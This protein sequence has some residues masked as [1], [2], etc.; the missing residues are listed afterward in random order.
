MDSHS[1]EDDFP[2][3]PDEQSTNDS[4]E[5]KSA[6]GEV[7]EDS[8]LSADQTNQPDPESPAEPASPDGEGNQSAPDSP[9]EEPQ[10]P[11]GSPTDASKTVKVCVCTFLPYDRLLFLQQFNSSDFPIKCV[12][13]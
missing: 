12:L 13:N 7:T 1:P 11:S 10:S 6:P 9:V 8:I 2:R 4:T 5:K 3:S